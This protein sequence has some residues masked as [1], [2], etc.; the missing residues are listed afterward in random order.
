[1]SAT[2]WGR[3]LCRPI[4]AEVGPEQC[5]EHLATVRHLQVQKFVYDDLFADL[6]GL[7]QDFRVEPQPSRGGAAPALVGHA[8]NV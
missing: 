2:V 1:V 7:E 3:Y 5:P 8:P 4:T 6:G